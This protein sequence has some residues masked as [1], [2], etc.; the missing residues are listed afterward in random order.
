MEGM[1]GALALDRTVLDWFVAHREPWLSKVFEVVTVLG[2]SV[3]LIPLVVSVGVWYRRRH[4]TSRPFALLAATYLGAYVMSQ[5]LKAII[6]RPRPPVGVAIGHYSDYAFPSGHATQVA[7]VWLMLAAVVAAGMP[8]SRH[9]MWVWVAATS[10]VVV[11]GFT[12]LYLAAHWLTDVL[13]GWAFG[14]LWFLAVLGAAQA[15]NGRREPPGARARIVAC[16]PLPSTPTGS[17]N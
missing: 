11:V 15:I 4:G 16:A 12:R 13:G 3:F 7:A 14:A 2:S 1:I 17:P 8:S 5:S 10:T 6:G 9:K